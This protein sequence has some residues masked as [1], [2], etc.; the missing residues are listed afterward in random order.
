MT[1]EDKQEVPDP[2][3]VS[4]GSSESTIS[5]GTG[6]LREVSTRTVSR[7]RVDEEATVSTGSSRITWSSQYT[8]RPARHPRTM[9]FRRVTSTR[10][11]LSPGRD[12]VWSHR[13][14]VLT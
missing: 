12:W 7:P 1:V 5:G 10:S 13:E 2:R 11:F 4:S 3:R 9:Y 14:V 8:V 6:D